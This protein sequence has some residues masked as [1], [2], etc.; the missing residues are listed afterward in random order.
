MTLAALAVPIRAS[1]LRLVY[2]DSSERSRGVCNGTSVGW[3]E[4]LCSLNI[5]VHFWTCVVCLLPNGIALH[6]IYIYTYHGTDTL[7]LMNVEWARW[8]SCK[9]LS[10][11]KSFFPSCLEGHF[12]AARPN[13]LW[14]GRC[15]AAPV[16]VATALKVR[17]HPSR[18]SRF[19]HAQLSHFL[20]GLILLSVVK[21]SVFLE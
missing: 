4:S 14:M 16:A 1:G 2:L 18:C 12:A 21:L 11:T 7:Q 8:S 5:F 9:F 10:E 3:E 6:A 15:W 19:L 20:S 13:N 17:H